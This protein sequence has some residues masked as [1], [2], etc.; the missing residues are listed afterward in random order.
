MDRQAVLIPVDGLYFQANPIAIAEVIIVEFNDGISTRA[1][2]VLNMLAE[3]NGTSIDGTPIIRTSAE[4]GGLI[5]EGLNPP[6]KRDCSFAVARVIRYPERDAITR[7]AFLIYVK[8]VD[9]QP[10]PVE[11]HFITQFE[12]LQNGSRTCLLGPKGDL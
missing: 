7:D 1:Q 8:Q 2:K 3:R 12:C 4:L 9:Q 10:L 5:S 6:G 11:P